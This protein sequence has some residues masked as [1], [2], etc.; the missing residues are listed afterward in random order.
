[1]QYGVRKVIIGNAQNLSDIV[2]EKSGT[3]LINE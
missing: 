2:L 1:L 3:I